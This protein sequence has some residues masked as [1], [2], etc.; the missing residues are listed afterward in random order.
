M[1]HAR[2]VSSVRNAG[3]CSAAWLAVLSS[4]LPGCPQDK[5]SLGDDRLKMN[6]AGPD[7]G[8]TMAGGAGGSLPA[9]SGG[10]GSGG[11]GGSGGRGFPPP[12]GF[13]PAGATCGGRSMASC[14]P[15]QFCFFD[16]GDHCGDDGETG[17]CEWLPFNGC[18]AEANPVCGCDGTTYGSPCLAALM[19]VSVR[20]GGRCSNSGSSGAPCGG[21]FPCPPGEF[22]RFSRDSGPCGSASAPGVCMDAPS[23]CSREERPVCGCDG[24]TYKNEC[25]AAMEGGVAAWRGGEC[26]TGSGGEPDGGMSWRTCGGEQGTPCTNGE[27]CDLAAGDGCDV[28]NARGECRPLPTRCTNV[29]E[30]VCSCDHENY[31]NACFAAARGV[32]VDHEGECQ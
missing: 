32:S 1:P 30:P 17:H 27:Y 4:A 2:A 8:G 3:L 6:D 22:C 19:G 15:V 28:E 16:S 25:F 20:N 9:G 24:V 10:A 26:P 31:P 5:V 23:S 7:G 13:P 14:P 29:F 21:P 18:P 11:S 12:G